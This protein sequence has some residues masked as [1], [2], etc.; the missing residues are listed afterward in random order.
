MS[1]KIFD[2]PSL[3]DLP[4]SY[5]K[6]IVKVLI[7]NPKVAY[8]LWDTKKMKYQDII[9]SWKVH[10]D[11][12]NVYLELNALFQNGIK[13]HM[14]IHLPP[15]TTSYYYRSRDPIRFLHAKLI[16]EAKGRRQSLLESPGVEI[17]NMLPSLK[18]DP[19]WVLEEWKPYL[20]NDSHS[21]ILYL[22]DTPL[23]TNKLLLDSHL[24]AHNDN[25]LLDGSSHLSSRL[26][27]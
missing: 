3:L 25:I 5:D 16:V 6:D 8:I 9:D 19:A 24:T 7:Q 4:L 27:S 2:D 18:V 1:F 20:H 23:T 10:S 26:S 15:F 13:T 21:E 14:N 22:S 11:E 17:P 12:I